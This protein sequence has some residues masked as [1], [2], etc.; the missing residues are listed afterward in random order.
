M[1]DLEI[2]RGDD[3]LGT[4]VGLW[5]NGDDG[6]FCV[7]WFT[8]LLTGGGVAGVERRQVFGRRII[9]HRSLVKNMAMHGHRSLPP[10]LRKTP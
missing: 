10:T 1:V 8:L 6:L 9:D 3:R 5:R 7:F 4:I 2:R